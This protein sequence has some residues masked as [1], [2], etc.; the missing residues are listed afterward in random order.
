MS[1]SR[2]PQGGRIDRSKPINFSWDK[3]TV[4]GFAGDTLASAMMASGETVFGRSFKYHRPRGIMSAGVEE[5]GA[6]VTVGSSSRRDPNVKAT[7]QEI[8]E[9]LEAFGQNAW[10][11][12]RTDL[13]AVNSLMSRF[14]SA[15][16]YYKTFMGVPPMEWGKGTG[17][18]MQYEKL[19]RKAAGMGV[20]SREP[21]PDSYEHGHK[22]CDV[23]V[24]GSGPAGL[25]AAVRAAESGLDVLLV[26]QDY[27][28]GGDYL[29]QIS[30]D[31]EEKRQSALK[32]LHA[33]G[34]TVMTRTT[35]FGL[36]DYSVAG[37]LERVTDHL[38]D[39]APHTPRQRFLTVRAKHTIPVS[40][41]HL[42]LPTICSV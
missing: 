6:I 29:N 16:F 40:Y 38:A 1:A 22:F 19:I 32:A 2:L 25:A 8:Y 9:G 12:V 11:N 42:T 18:W 28:A 27:E 31:A 14:F 35:A 21:D 36:Y 26:E 20:A 34:A 7:T 5:S 24:V 30:P 23:L 3:K 41:T 39:P 4:K 33:A 13:G 17:I 37:L 10:P 15:G